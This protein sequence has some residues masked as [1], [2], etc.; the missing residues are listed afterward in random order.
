[1]SN[2]CLCEWA[3]TKVVAN[4]KNLSKVYTWLSL[5]AEWCQLNNGKISLSHQKGCC[6]ENLHKGEVRCS[7]FRFLF[8]FSHIMWNPFWQKF[9]KNDIYMSGYKLSWKVRMFLE[10]KCALI[11]GN[12]AVVDIEID[13]TGRRERRQFERLRKKSF[14]REVKLPQLFSETL[15]QRRLKRPQLK[16]EFFFHTC[17]DSR[18]LPVLGWRNPKRTKLNKFRLRTLL[19]TDRDVTIICGYIIL[20]IVAIRKKIAKIKYGNFTTFWCVKISVAS[21]DEAFGFV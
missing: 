12:Y 6:H 9:K 13:A 7:L 1:M 2:S 15:I 11:T 16:K 18:L 8:E 4:K 10:T 20:R 21:D 14:G 3:C 5:S 19:T 17:N